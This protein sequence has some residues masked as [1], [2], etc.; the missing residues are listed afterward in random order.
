MCLLPPRII[1]GFD[2]P[3]WGIFQ[4][5]RFFARELFEMFVEIL[6]V[7]ILFRLAGMIDRLIERRRDVLYY[8][9]RT[10]G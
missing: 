9:A 2:L 7:F 10:S 5:S 4:D 6:F 3:G 1:L 8:V